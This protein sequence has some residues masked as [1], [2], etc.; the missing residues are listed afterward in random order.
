M[1]NSDVW[2]IA[3]GGSFNPIHPEHVEAIVCARELLEEEGKVV[4][5]AIVAV[6]PDD[7]VIRKFRKTG[8]DIRDVIPNEHR[9]KIFN[10]AVAKDHPWIHAFGP[11]GYGIT[12][13]QEFAPQVLPDIDPSRFRIANCVGADYVGT[14]ITS[15]P[16]NGASLNICVFRKG[17]GEDIKEKMKTPDASKNFRFIERS[18]RGLSSTSLRDSLGHK[19]LENLDQ[20][21]RIEKI[22]ELVDSVDLSHGAANYIIANFNDIY[23]LPEDTRNV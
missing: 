8:A 23:D 12:C 7:H 3:M 6:A 13:A 17:Y 14:K 2:I 16:K 4:G 9:V 15:E 10:A 20:N 5:A 21:K 19:A 18:S 1:E 11:H 22:K